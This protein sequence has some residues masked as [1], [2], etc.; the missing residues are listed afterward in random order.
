MARDKAEKETKWYTGEVQ[1]EGFPLHLRFPER[2]DFDSLQEKF[3]SLLLA[4]HKLDRVKPSGV[5]EA[6]YNASLAD[7]DH[8]LITAFEQPSTGMT[9]LVETFGGMRTYYMYVSPH[10]QIDATKRRFFRKVSAE[11]T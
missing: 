1:H 2:P 7:F 5:P 4:T 6:A 10:A 9:V 11:S 3:S 8:D